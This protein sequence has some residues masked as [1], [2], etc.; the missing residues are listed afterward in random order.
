[1]RRLKNYAKIYSLLYFLFSALLHSEMW[2]MG[3]FEVSYP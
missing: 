2:N 3:Y 1:M